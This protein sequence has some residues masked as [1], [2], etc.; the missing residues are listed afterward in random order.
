VFN[1]ANAVR[2]ATASVCAAQRRAR[3]RASRRL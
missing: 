2:G 3:G 1:L